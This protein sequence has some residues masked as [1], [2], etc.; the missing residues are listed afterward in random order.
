MKLSKIIDILQN[1][2]ET[3]ALAPNKARLKPSVPSFSKILIFF[4]F[5]GIF[6]NAKDFRTLHSKAWQQSNLNNSAIALYGTAKFSTI[7]K[8]DKIELIVPKITI[9]DS[10][11]IPVIIKSSLQAK[12]V[13][14]FQD[15]ENKSLIVVFNVLKNAIVESHLQIQASKY[16][17]S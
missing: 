14:L 15:K 2:S 13:A 4:L 1:F 5:L 8:S 17:I 7:Q 6:L 10:S 12:S 9:S 16:S 3:E 11:N